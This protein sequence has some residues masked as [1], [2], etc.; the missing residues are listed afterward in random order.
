MDIAEFKN[1]FRRLSVSE[2]LLLLH[3]LWDE[4]AADNSTL[5]LSSDEQAELEQRFAEH[6]SAPGTGRSWDDVRRDIRGRH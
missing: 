3:E 1:G 6:V 5:D 4:L 2:R